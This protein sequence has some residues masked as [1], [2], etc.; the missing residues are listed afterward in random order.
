MQHVPLKSR[1]RSCSCSKLIDG[2]SEIATDDSQD[3]R[4]DNPTTHITKKTIR[5]FA[6]SAR[7]LTVTCLPVALISA[8]GSPPIPPPVP[9]SPNQSLRI[10][11]TA[12]HQRR[13]SPGYPIFQELNNSIRNATTHM[14]DWELP[15]RRWEYGIKGQRS[16]WNNHRS[17][18]ECGERRD[19]RS[20]ASIKGEDC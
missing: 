5:F 11:L 10:G 18:E 8:R 9:L 6:S 3:M 14:K 17:S 15:S 7:S 12:P 13:R 4:Y 19:G 2:I 1:G 20:L 16:S